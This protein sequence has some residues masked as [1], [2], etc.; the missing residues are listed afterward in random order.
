MRVSERYGKQSANNAAPTRSVGW[1]LA[2]FAA[3]VV[4]LTL[5]AAASANVSFTK[6]YGWG[7]SDGASQF[8]TCTSTCQVG[9][10]GAGAGQLDY[11]W[12]IATD[13]SGDVYVA[14]Y[15][16]NRIDEFSAA[17]AFIKAY[18][19]GV[20]DGASQFETCTSTCLRGISGAGFGQDGAGQFDHVTGVATDS[21]GDV[22]VAEEGGNRIDEFSAGGAFIKAYGWGV[23]DGMNK[24]ETCTSTCQQGIAGR[25][26]GE[27][28]LATGVATDSSG[29]VYVAD[30][31]NQRIDEFSAAGAFVKAYGW[32]VSNGASQ[33]ETCTSTCQIGLAG[34]GAGQFYAPIGVATDSS[35]DV[36][37]ADQANNRIDEFSAAGSFIKAYGW[38]VSDG[39]SQFET[40]TSTCFG[41]LSGGGAGSFNYPHG[42]ATDSSGDVYVAD[43]ADWRIEEFSAGGAPPPS[44]LIGSPADGQTFSLNQSVATSFSCSEASGGPG[45]Q[46][47]TDS[48][49]STSPG[50]LHTSTAGT[51]TYTVT[52]RSEDGQMGTATISY[53]VARGSQAIA[54]ISRAPTTAV[55]GGPRYAVAATGGASGNPVTFSSATNSVCTVSGSTVS[56]VGAGMCTLDANQAGNSD[57]T[58]APTATQSFTV[59]AQAAATGNIALDGF[60][61]T[62]QRNHEA[63]IK[64][65]CTGTATCSGRLTLTVKRTTGKGK[66]RHTKTQTIGTATFSIPAGKSETVK[67]TLNGTG[68]ALL[69]AAHGHLSSTLA[70]LKS[71]PSPSKTQT[72]NVHLAQQ[73]AKKSKK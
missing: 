63:L 40:C 31:G 51:L 16:S 7:V 17:G 24:F 53:T 44:A 60:T 46:S 62:V 19:W 3:L 26:A 71:S 29:D 47:C 11:P 8:E 10:Q 35:G 42:V 1:I 20:S 72:E 70:I 41:G 54:F 9:R 65:T 61:I 25:G 50:A 37:V 59:V 73:K 23:L 30:S 49:G 67:L 13:P 33:F 5:T 52:A 58:P 56:F 12:G 32:G 69:S 45:I 64:L 68:R 36:Y 14:D 15:E 34:G 4:S 21:S 27:L 55:A 22:Y 38:G 28:D 57:Y 18:G 43:S 66:K 48:N 6:A 39:A 2:L